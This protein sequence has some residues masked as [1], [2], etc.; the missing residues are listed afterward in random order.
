MSETFPFKEWTPLN[1]TIMGGMSDASCSSTPDGLLVKGCLVEENGG[2]VSC[3]SRILF[4]PIDL[5]MY[6]GIQIEIDAEGQTLKFAVNCNDSFL[7]ASSLFFDRIRWVAEVKTKKSGTTRINIPFHNFQPTFRS[8]PL[9]YNPK[10][11]TDA[12]NQLQLL[13]SKFGMPGKQ[14]NTFMPG[15]FRILLRSLNVYN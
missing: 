2:F 3:R 4:K 11:R 13:Y 5:S 1:D 8:E 6:E 9:S 12:I 14:N 7:H 10:F 15:P